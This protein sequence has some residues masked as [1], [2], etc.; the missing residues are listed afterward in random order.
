MAASSM[1]IVA[2]AGKIDERGEPEIYVV[3]RN[4]AAKR[5]TGVA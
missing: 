4:E 3:W 5:K 2:Q 1:V